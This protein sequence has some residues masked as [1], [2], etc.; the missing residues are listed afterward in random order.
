MNRGAPKA[1]WKFDEGSGT[2]S[3]DASGNSYTGTLTGTPTWGDG[4][5]NTGITLNGS[6]QYSTVSDSANIRFDANTQDFSV[7][8]WVKRSSSGSE[9]NIVS[10]EDADN[11]GYR[12]Q[13]TSGNIVRCSVN[14]IDIDSTVT[15]TDTTNWHLVGCTITRAG[16]GQVYID[17]KPTG[18]ATAISSTAMATTTGLRIGA[19]S[20]TVANY[21][22]GTVDDVRLYNYALTQSQ[23]R[24]LL[25]EGAGVRYGP[26]S[27]S[28]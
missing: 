9:M 25:N 12:L 22:A 21:F 11:D 2:T 1:W 26:A 5:F 17:G 24:K 3:N 23:I 18:T 10:K 14:T 28:P 8:A 15:I 27:G 16:N 4:R 6:T 13:F 19:R 20:Y 7:F